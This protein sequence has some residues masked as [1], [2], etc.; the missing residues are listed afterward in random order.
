MI[1]ILSISSWFMVVLWNQMIRRFMLQFVN[2]QIFILWFTSLPV[3][4]GNLE[5]MTCFFCPTFR[6]FGVRLQNW[7]TCPVSSILWHE[8]MREY[9]QFYDL[10]EWILVIYIFELFFVRCFQCKPKLSFG[11]LCFKNWPLVQF[12]FYF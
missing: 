8:T 6:Q 9:R 2:V 4:T 12:G 1:R 10:W 7:T 11:I 3:V 5:L